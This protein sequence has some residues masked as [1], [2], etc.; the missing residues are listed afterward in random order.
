[1]IHVID[2]KRLSL[3]FGL[4]KLLISNK[5]TI[6]KLDAYEENKIKLY[7]KRMKN[8]EDCLEY[9][10]NRFYEYYLTFKISRRINS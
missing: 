7:N 10:N 1:M 4:L 3:F 2:F 8:L 6:A 9:L 5:K